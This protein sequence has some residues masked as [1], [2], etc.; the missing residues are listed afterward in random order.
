MNAKGVKYACRSSGAAVPSSATTV[1]YRI[2]LRHLWAEATEVETE[3]DNADPG[4]V[5]KLLEFVERNR[6]SIRD[7]KDG[8]LDER[9]TISQL[10]ASCPLC[11]AGEN[12]VLEGGNWIKF[13]EWGYGKDPSPATVGAANQ[14][15]IPRDSM[16]GSTNRIEIVL[17]Y[18]FFEGEK[19][20][21]SEDLQSGYGADL[22][23]VLSTLSDGRWPSSYQVKE[24]GRFAG[25]RAF[26]GL[27]RCAHCGKVFAT[28]YSICVSSLPFLTTNTIEALVSFSSQMKRDPALIFE[29]LSA[30][31]HVPLLSIEARREGGRAIIVASTAKARSELEFDSDTG[32]TTIDGCSYI[33][34]NRFIFEKLY[35][36]KDGIPWQ[37]IFLLREA[38]ESLADLLPKVPEGVELG[39]D[40]E[41]RLSPFGRCRT[42][43]LFMAANRF[44]GYPASFFEE[45]I[46]KE[47]VEEYEELAVAL[48]IGFGL[49]HAYSDVSG[50]CKV[51]GLPDD[52]LVRKA[53]FERPMLLLKM[54]QV[55]S[56]PFRDVGVLCEFLRHP[57]AVELLRLVGRNLYS[58]SGWKK[59]A[60][61]KGDEQILEY[62][63]GHSDEEIAEASDR[64]GVRSAPADMG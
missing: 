16:L 56:I 22:S 53:L 46:S 37:N 29:S 21:L 55:S 38:V 26:C 63:V 47:G 13:Q 57:R 51:L 52:E 54:L 12:Q 23:G 59:L 11:E 19:D 10:I 32:I 24:I 34:D 4:C 7:M 60:E 27:Y 40:S 15:W 50:A 30:Q 31:V 20:D 48:P 36:R 39:F 49:P 25:S 17:D 64:I 2:P 18:L 61:A 62:L 3:F 14:G 8:Y 44:A 41:G 9:I 45:L 43:F 42:L 6:D 35:H 58:A 33:K 5:A 1:T 28:A